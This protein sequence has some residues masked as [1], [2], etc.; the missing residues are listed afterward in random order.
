MQRSPLSN[1][2]E[3][4][5]GPTVLL[6]RLYACREDLEARLFDVSCVVCYGVA[7]EVHW[8]A[9]PIGFELAPVGLRAQGRHQQASSAHPPAHFAKETWKFSVGEMGKRV[10]GRHAVEGLGTEIQRE[11]VLVEKCG[12]RDVV[13]GH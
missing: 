2:P 3:E 9:E 5:D 11:H 13:S 12:G 10:E 4:G 1:Y 7:A 8:G 6:D